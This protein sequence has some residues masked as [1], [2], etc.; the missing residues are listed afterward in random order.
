MNHFGQGVF[1]GARTNFLVETIGLDP[2]Q[3]L[4][5][6]G[7][8]EVPGLALRLAAA[9]RLKDVLKGAS[10]SPLSVSELADGRDRAVRQGAVS[11]GAVLFVN[12]D[13]R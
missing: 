10:F 7:I 8:R 5:L 4:W 6:E 13:R 2:S 12:H 1:G 3:V 11:A 9:D